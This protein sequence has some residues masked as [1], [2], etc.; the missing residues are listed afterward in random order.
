MRDTFTRAQALLALLSAATIAITTGAITTSA[1]AQAPTQAQRAAI[2]SQCR[3]DYIAHCSSISP[4]GAASLQCLQ[5]NMASLAP[6]CQAAVQAITGSSEAKSEPKSESKS[7][8]AAPA[9]DAKTQDSKTQDSKTQVKPDATTENKSEPAP[10]A[11]P[12]RATAS[13]SSSMK[14]P[15]SAQV[16]AIRSACRSDYPKVCAGVPTGGAQALQ[17][18]QKNKASVSPA[19]QN[20]VAAVAAGTAAPAGSASAQEAAT[21]PAAPAATPAAPSAGPAIVL[22]PMRPREVVFVLRSACGADARTLCAGVD[23]GGGRILQCLAS[24]ATSL[25]P[26]CRSVLSQ[27]AGR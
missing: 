7:E 27:F 25:S 19:C 9:A 22:R 26:D 21:S 2:K 13:K 15:S 16:A 4:G 24:N 11:P 6:G 10:A 1:T 5:K 3:A 12:A 20:A 18:L 23:P 14:K 17:C 8:T